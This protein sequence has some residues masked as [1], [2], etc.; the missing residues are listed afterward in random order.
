MAIS[1]PNTTVLET[2]MKEESGL[3][4]G[5]IE[6]D[7]TVLWTPS[8]KPELCWTF[9]LRRKIEQKTPMTSGLVDLA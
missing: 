3:E 6:V 2:I 4:K 5:D 9:M 8:M 1:T 7:A